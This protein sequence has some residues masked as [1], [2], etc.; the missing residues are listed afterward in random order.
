MTTNANVIVSNTASTAITS[1][2]N[3]Q[4]NSTVISQ[5][6]LSREN[7]FSVLSFEEFV[8]DFKA[9]RFV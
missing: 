9:V 2:I 7:L 6:A 8:A 5:H 3:S 1:A 4:A